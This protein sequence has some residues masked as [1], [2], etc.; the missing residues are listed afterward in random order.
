MYYDDPY[1]PTLENDYDDAPDEVF[2]CSSDSTSLDSQMKKQRKFLE[3]TKA[4]DKGYCKLK[5]PSVLGNSFSAPV[6]IEIYSSDG[7][8]TRIR[9]AITGVKYNQFRVGTSDEYLFFKVNMATGEKALRGNSVFFFDD[10]EQYERHMKCLLSTQTK[11]IWSERNK[12][13]LARRRLAEN[14]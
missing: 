5:R 6:G 4:L 14:I 10:P 12:K 7:I 2:S 9:G 8:G 1:D 3:E 13:E 11:T